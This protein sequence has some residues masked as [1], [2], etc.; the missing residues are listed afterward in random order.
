MPAN[1]RV[2]QSPSIAYSVF[3]ILHRILSLSSYLVGQLHTWSLAV[4]G[5]VRAT[6][7]HPVGASLDIGLH[8]IFAS[9]MLVMGVAMFVGCMM[10][11][12]HTAIFRLMRWH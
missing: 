7:S 6:V 11:C 9:A 3:F 1:E 10:Q 8:F 12:I 5:G 2:Q 4:V